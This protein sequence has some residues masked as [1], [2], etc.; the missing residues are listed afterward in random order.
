MLGTFT[1]HSKGIFAACSLPGFPVNYDNE[2][3]TENFR[4]HVLM[5]AAFRKDMGVE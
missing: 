3:S 5:L 1:L 4:R 2:G